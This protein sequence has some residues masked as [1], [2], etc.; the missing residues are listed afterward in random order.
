MAFSG[1]VSM[2]AKKIV[3]IISIVLLVL[4]GAFMAV[5][6]AQLIPVAMMEAA[7]TPSPTPRI[8]SVAV[9]TPDPNAPTAPPLLKN[10]SEGEDVIRLQNRLKELGYY[11]STVDGQYGAGTRSAVMQFQ[12]QHGLDDDG[13]AGPDTVNML[14][15]AQA[16]ALYTPTPRPT[17]PP[18]A[19]PTAAPAAVIDRKPYVRPDGLPLLVNKVCA[20]PDGYET[21]DLVVMNDYCDPAVVKIKYANTEAEREAVD[22]LIV[23][24]KA[25]IADG[26]DN[27]Q[28][29]AAYRSVAYQQ[30]LFDKQVSTY[31]KENNLSRTKAI[32][33]TRRTVADPG[34]S[35]HHVGTAFDI[36]VPGKSF[37]GTKQ[38]DWLAEN[39]WNYGF[40]LRYTKEKEKITGY[41]AEAWH[42]RYVGT[43]HSIPMYNED[44]CLEEYIEKYGLVIEEE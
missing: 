27:W 8:G 35:E 38:A 4:A 37:A 28:I 20:L 18:T 9:I 1:F 17:L 41:T 31:M 19:V 25:A 43:E 12:Q 39:C 32:S 29:S 40:I 44:L 34:Y 30:Q 26:V 33:A 22:A 15:S 13:V 10:G 6:V 11:T 14:Y 2:S 42:F 3:A 36:T 21:Y 7:V 24:L 16:H 5:R 23:M